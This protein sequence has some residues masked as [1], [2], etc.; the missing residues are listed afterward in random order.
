MRLQSHDQFA[1]LA[2]FEPERGELV[3]VSRDGAG[4]LLDEPLAGHFSWSFGVLAVLYRH[5]DTL[6]LR[7][8]DTACPLE[9]AIIDW[10][11][12]VSSAQLCVEMPTGV[13]VFEYPVD[14]PLAF[15]FTACAEPEDFD[16]GLFVFA[17]ASDSERSAL[18]WR[19]G[20]EPQG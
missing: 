1:L 20:P 2:R 5:N 18:I 16:F 19:P 10:S 9:H 8:G 4:A 13:R 3:E 7:V 17:I 15:D 6:W 12:D 14:P 11:R